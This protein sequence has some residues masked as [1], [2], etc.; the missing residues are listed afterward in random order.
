VRTAISFEG[1]DQLAG[2]VLPKRTVLSTLVTPFNSPGA[3]SAGDTSSSSA[4]AAG[5]SGGGDHGTT[6]MSA[7]QSTWTGG[8]GGLLG[9]LGLGT[10]PS[11]SVTCTPAAVSGH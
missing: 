5:G 11:S 9:A 3:G 1:L 7:C 10:P 8:T 6:A 2:E 4:A